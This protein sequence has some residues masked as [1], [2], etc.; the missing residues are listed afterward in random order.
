MVATDI[1]MAMVATAGKVFIKR[2]CIANHWQSRFRCY[3][4]IC[5]GFNSELFHGKPDGSDSVESRRKTIDCCLFTSDSSRV[6]DRMVEIFGA[7]DVKSSNIVV[8][9]FII[10]VEA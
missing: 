5:I 3:R 10:P 4:Y 6:I 2:I 8:K 7:G 9:I 1:G